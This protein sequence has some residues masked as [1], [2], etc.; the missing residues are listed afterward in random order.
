MAGRFRFS[1]PPRRHHDDPWFRI[2]QL[3][4]TTT[5]LVSLICVVT[6]FVWAISPGFVDGALEPLV[7]FPDKVTSGQIWRLFTWPFVSAP[8]PQ[9]LWTVVRIA[10]FW[11]FAR[12][13]EA[14]IGR[15]KFAILLGI[16]VLVC[17]LV[18]TGLDVPLAGLRYVEIPIFVLYVAE[19]PGAQFFFGI[20]GWIIAVVFVGAESLDLVADRQWE[21]LVVLAVSIATGLLVGRYYGLAAEQKWIPHIGGGRNRS[22]SSRSR[23]S[24]R[25]RGNRGPAVVAGPWEG[26]TVGSSSAQAEVDRLL[27]KISAVG[28]DGLT[29]DEKRRLKEASERLRRERG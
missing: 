1:F 29:A 24:S 22:R 13:I 20:P 11:W 21:L 27:D 18:A 14:Q 23:P 3:D 16:L 15:V 19:H 9:F 6:I 25:T 7:L 4:V 28:M 5:V 17:G 26:S 12:D 10:L 2:G 8:D